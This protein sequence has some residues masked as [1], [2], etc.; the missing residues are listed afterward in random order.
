[1]Q[2]KCKALVLMTE[3]RNSKMFSTVDQISKELKTKSESICS[4][5]WRGKKWPKTTEKSLRT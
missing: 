1:M 5:A 2:G 4:E 3:F